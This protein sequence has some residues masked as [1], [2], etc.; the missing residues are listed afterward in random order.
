MSFKQLQIII[1]FKAQ[2][3]YHTST[4][5]SS[6]FLVS[7]LFDHLSFGMLENCRLLRHGSQILATAMS[8]TISSS[9]DD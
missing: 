6:L 5:T 1:Q 9:V 7:Q 3:Y 2:A 8:N 4:P